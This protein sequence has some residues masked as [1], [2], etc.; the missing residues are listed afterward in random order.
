MSKNIYI[1]P[2]KEKLVSRI[3]RKSTSHKGLYQY[4]IDYCLPEGSEVLAA[5]DGKVVSVEDQSAKGGN[6]ESFKDSANYIGL[7]HI[8]EEFSEY[9]HLKKDSAKISV[10]ES[11]QSGQIIGLSG[12]TGYS[13]EPHLHF[14]VGKKTSTKPGWKSIEI[15]FNNE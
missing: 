5:H 8:N 10:G 11:V 9:L 12:N 2:C 13:S 6:D 3:V 7:Q 15:T 1:I 4:A 14:L